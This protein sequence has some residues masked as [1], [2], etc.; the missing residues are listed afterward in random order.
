MRAQRTLRLPAVDDPSL[1][2]VRRLARGVH[3]RSRVHG[4]VVR[5]EASSHREADEQSEENGTQAAHDHP[6][7]RRDGLLLGLVFVVHWTKHV[8]VIAADAIA[9]I[10]G[11]SIHITR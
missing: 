8:A 1:V 4:G 3:D 7:V 11:S 10:I 6:N 2:E 9:T 5:L